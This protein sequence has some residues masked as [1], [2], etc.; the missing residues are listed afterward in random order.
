MQ[1]LS[2]GS[3][4]HRSASL[5]LGALALLAALAAC[6]PDGTG[7]TGVTQ[8]RLG[9]SA[10][11]QQVTGS[12]IVALPFFDN[13]RQKYTNSIIRHADGSVSGQFEV[14]SEQEDGVR[15]HGRVLC[16]GV[17]GNQA[18]VGGVV[19]Q[20]STPDIADGTLLVWRIVDNGEGANAPPD[21]TSDFFSVNATQQAYHCATGFNLQLLPVLSGNM[22]VRP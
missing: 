22:Q 11:Q 21:Q 8:P 17:V 10:P 13:A 15:V 16:V 7:D 1:R 5:S 20:S 18:Y 14:Q 3:L 19:E 9:A 6:S 2:S 4:T 12:A